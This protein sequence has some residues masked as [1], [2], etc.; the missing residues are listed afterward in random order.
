MSSLKIPFLSSCIILTLLSGKC[1]LRYDHIYF[2]GSTTLFF[3]PQSATFT[4][5][6]ALIS[7]ST[8]AVKWLTRYR[9]KQFYSLCLCIFSSELSDRVL[10]EFNKDGII[11]LL[12]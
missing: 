8:T 3:L 11:I 12:L 7:G 4:L 1:Y 6:Y 2:L 10:S 9:L 5:H